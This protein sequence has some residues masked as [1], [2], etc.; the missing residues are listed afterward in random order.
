MTEGKFFP[1]IDNSEKL[2][3][4]LLQLNT[5]SKAVWGRMDA[6]QMIEHLILVCE[7]SNGTKECEVHTPEK[8]IEK[9]QAFLMSDEPM[10]KNFIA[11]FIPEEPAAH[12]YENIEASIN[13][14]ISSI[15]QYHSYWNGKEETTR[16]HP[17]FGKLNKHKWDM[18]HN[19]HITHHLL[20]FGLK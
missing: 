1:W 12:R 11:K 15:V 16:N 14:F 13:A 3:Q 5:E 18:V 17:V 20:Q 4:I 10:P 6:Q 7:L 9:S 8:Y 19:K 2:K